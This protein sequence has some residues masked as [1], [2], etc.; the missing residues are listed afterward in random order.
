MNIATFLIT[1]SLIAQLASICWYGTE[2]HS[3][4]GWVALFAGLCMI[5]DRAARMDDRDAFCS[6]FLQSVIVFVIIFSIA[7]LR[8]LC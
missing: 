6:F 5:T 1:G 3:L 7:I 4:A 8:V 2:G